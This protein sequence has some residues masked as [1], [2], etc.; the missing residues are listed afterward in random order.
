M[1]RYYGDHSFKEI[2]FLVRPASY[3]Q[4][5]LENSN[6]EVLRPSKVPP[7]HDGRPD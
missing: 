1:K 3:I 2:I 6:G 5:S 4:N 7:S